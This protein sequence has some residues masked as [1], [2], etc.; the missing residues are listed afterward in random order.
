[1]AQQTTDETAREIAR[2]ALARAQEALTRHSAHDGT[3]AERW[4][5]IRAALTEI[6]NAV[7]R[8]RDDVSKLHDEDR[9]EAVASRESRIRLLTWLCGVLVTVLLAVAGLAIAH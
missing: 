8:L 9:S 1:M 2:K 7:D 6:W 5:E 4:T 3:C